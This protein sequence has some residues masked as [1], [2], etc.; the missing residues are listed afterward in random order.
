M[1]RIDSCPVCL[2]STAVFLPRS[3]IHCCATAVGWHTY[4]VCMVWVLEQGCATVD[5][6]KEGQRDRQ[7]AQH[8]QHAHID[9]APSV[10]ANVGDDV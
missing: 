7:G 6:G 9:A 1:V 8:A 4:G 2:S 10:L 3:G 5:L